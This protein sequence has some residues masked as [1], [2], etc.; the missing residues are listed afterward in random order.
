MKAEGGLGSVRLR[1]GLKDFEDLFQTKSFYDRLAKGNQW[2]CFLL[3]HSQF[4]LNMKTIYSL[5]KPHQNQTNSV[6]GYTSH[7][8]S[9]MP[10]NIKRKK[11]HFLPD[12]LL[13]KSP[14]LPLTSVEGGGFF[15]SSLVQTFILDQYSIDMLTFLRL[16][17]SNSLPGRARS[18]P[19]SHFSSAMYKFTLALSMSLNSGI[20][21]S[22][23]ILSEF[24]TSTLA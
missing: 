16:I 8:S 1:A 19:S 7:F 18:V 12:L 2:D 13:S 24:T 14:I 10:Q 23:S 11:A 20:Y 17:P 5:L 15:Q 3:Y 4:F 6:L 9:L 21:H 22:W